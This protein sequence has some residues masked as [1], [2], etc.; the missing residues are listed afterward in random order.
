MRPLRLAPQLTCTRIPGAV[1][2]DPS[3]GSRLK[4]AA[5]GWGTIRGRSGDYYEVQFDSASRRPKRNGLRVRELEDRA[6]ASFDV[7]GWLA[8]VKK[9]DTSP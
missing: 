7:Y 9:R 8:L 5:L 4:H 6:G 2:P 3:V 1:S